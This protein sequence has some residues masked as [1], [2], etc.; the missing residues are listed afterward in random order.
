MTSSLTDAQ[1]EQYSRHILLPEIDTE[2]Q[3]RFL[4]SKVLIIGLGGLGSPTAMYLA[5]SGV[6]HI[7]LCDHDHVE[8]GNLQRQIIH[9]H[10][11]V[12]RA[13]VES[14]C[15]TLKSINPD[16]HIS[17]VNQKLTGKLLNEQVKHADLVIDACDNFETR[18]EIN[19]AC[20]DHKTSL[21]SGAAIGMSGQVAIF[22]HKTNSPCYRC[23]YSNNDNHENEDCL[24]NGVLAPLVGIIGSIMATEALKVLADFGTSLAG[25]LLVVNAY[26]MTMRP[27]TLNKDPECPACGNKKSHR[28]KTSLTTST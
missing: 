24:S 13:K 6:G 17:T 22:N 11:D 8:L 18:F 21:V 14:A 19:Q 28:D 25:R 27:I 23:L 12:K 4:Q 5:S 26:D 15:D 2:G 3:Q 7:T 20:I 16:T 1:L 9:R 10:K